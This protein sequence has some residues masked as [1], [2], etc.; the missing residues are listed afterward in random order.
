MSSPDA[1]ATVTETLRHLVSTVK[2]GVT[3]TTKPPSTARG[4]SNG[5]QINIFLYST[6]YNPAF[7]ND[8]MP[9]APGSDFPPMPL[10]LKYLITAYGANDDD[11][12]GQV[13]MGRAMRLLH[14]HPLLG[15]ED[16]EGIMPDSGLQRQTERIRITPDTLTLD[17]MSKLW[18]SFQSTEY[19]LSVG[20]EVSVVLIESSRT[21]TAALP[22]LR[23]GEE[24]RGVRVLP[25]PT[26]RLFGLRFP[27]QKPAAELDNTVT[28]LGEHLSRENTTVRFHHPLFKDPIPLPPLSVRD[29]GELLVQLP[30][31]EDEP[32]A[33][34][35]WP[36]GFYTLSLLIQ[37][38]GIPEHTSNQL[39]MPLAPT[40]RSVEPTTAQADLAFVL[41]VECIPQ[42]R[43][44]EQE[45][46]L[47]F[48]DQIIASDVVETPADATASSRVL[49]TVKAPAKPEPYVVRLRVDGVDSIP[50][51]FSGNRARFADN[52]KVTV[53]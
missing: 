12:S 51:D 3:V 17:D 21:G 40:I 52:Q 1:L 20:Y 50:V 18:T 22:V 9:G 29:K 49:F 35:T 23:R 16:I 6:Y 15:R 5:E 33:T 45:V 41:T 19:R 13:L 28:L 43:S 48:G 11:I 53:S 44:E 25:G 2:A 4:G 31:L 39:S 47:L 26:A 37:K 30:Q 42:I 38:P 7:R 24:D 8:P 46:M 10:V 36:A 32:E 14:D 34:S 27:F